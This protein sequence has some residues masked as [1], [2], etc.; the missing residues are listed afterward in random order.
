[1]IDV[2]LRD[3]SGIA[4]ASEL[5]ALPEPP[6]IVLV[7]AD[8]DAASPDGVR[9]WRVRP[10]HVPA[11]NLSASS[12]EVAIS[13]PS[14]SLGDRHGVGTAVRFPGTICGW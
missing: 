14:T 8:P 9:R 6:R 3:G 5:A 11:R 12:A 2:R 13:Q 1:M 7:S 10:R 4:L